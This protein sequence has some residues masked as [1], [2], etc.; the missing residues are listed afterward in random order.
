MIKKEKE[1]QNIIGHEI[2]KKIHIKTDQ[3]AI[4]SSSGGNSIKLM[5]PLYL[6]ILNFEDNR[7]YIPIIVH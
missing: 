6:T 5:A 2:K 3:Y 1:K 4:F 7:A